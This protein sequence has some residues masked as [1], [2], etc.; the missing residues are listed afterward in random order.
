MSNTVQLTTLPCGLRVATCEMPQAQTAAMGIWASVGGRH[1]PAGRNGIS[2]FIEHMLF[3]GTARRSA[4]RIMQ[5]IEGV[6]GDM[7]AY[8]AEEQ[9]CYYATAAAEY[10]PR[11]CDVLCDIYLNPRFSRRDID[12]ERGVIGEEILMYRDEPSSH[13][14]ELLNAT[15]WPRHPLGRPLTGTL[16][17]IEGLGRKEFLDYRASHYHS[18]ST[19]VTAAGRLTH[20]QVVA[21]VGKALAGLGKGRKPAAKPAPVPPS[22]PR[23]CVEARDIQ[24]TQVAV[25]LPG[26]SHKDERRFAM[27]LLHILLGG[28]AS[29]RLFQELR[30]KR[31]LCYSVN[32]HLLT[33][34]DSGVL[35]ITAGLDKKN[36]EKSLRL[37]LAEFEVLRKKIVGKAEFKRAKEYAIGSSRMSL[38]RSSSQNMRLGGSVLVH[39]KVIDPETV[40]EKIRAVTPE[41]VRSAAAEILDPSRMTLALVGPSPDERMLRKVLGL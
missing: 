28:N 31:G 40:H 34:D 19:V 30:E 18:T 4:R 39:G 35:N 11:V 24:Q 9:T 37:I 21:R 16:E 8:T 41:E 36:L 20:G 2:H 27:H 29:S 7:N 32:T 15:Y 23:L 22:Q 26:F 33:L 38:E 13:V 6:G 5:E 12:R 25:A 14:A 3:K 10:F 17:T 1:E